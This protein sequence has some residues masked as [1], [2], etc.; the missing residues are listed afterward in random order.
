[1]KM[2]T[3]PDEALSAVAG[4]FQALA[5]PMRLQM[6]NRLREREHNVGEL[7]A[8]CGCS[9]ANA[10]RHLALLQQ[11]GLV[12]RETRGTS[13]YFTIADP[14]LHRLCDLVCD[15]IARQY[16]RS[17]SRHAAFVTPAPAPRA[18]SGAPF[19]ARSATTSARKR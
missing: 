1:M 12:A 3:L 19:G 14:T 16:E 4:Y 18:A 17:A 15:N 10:S 9:I 7:A 5:E 6:L 2:Q 11:H 13:A 8:S